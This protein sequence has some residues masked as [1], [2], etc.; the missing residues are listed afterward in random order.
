MSNE[1]RVRISFTE[2]LRFPEEGSST[3]GKSGPKLRPKGVGDG[4]QVDIP[5]PPRYRLNDGA[6][7]EDMESA[8]MVVCAQAVREMDRQ[9]R[10]TIS[11]RDGEGTIV[12]KFQRSHCRENHIVSYPVTVPEHDTGRRGENPKVSGRTLVK[13]LGKMTP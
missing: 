10:P 5:V 6:T 9:I 12:T 13:E 1:K 8:R 2:S 11:S 4:E 3:Q 7:Q